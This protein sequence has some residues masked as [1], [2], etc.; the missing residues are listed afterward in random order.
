[1]LCIL[2]DPKIIHLKDVHDSN[3]PVNRTLI[4]TTRCLYHRVILDDGDI[5]CAAI[6]H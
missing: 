5:C 3:N 6:N 4:D 2:N 1:M